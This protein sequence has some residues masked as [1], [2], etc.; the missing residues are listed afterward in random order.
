[1]SENN[2]VPTPAPS[3]VAAFQSSPQDLPIAK[4]FFVFSK[5]FV[6]FF[7]VGVINTFV[8]LAVLNVATTIT[9]IKDGPGF[10]IQKALSF[11]VAVIGSYFLNKRWTFKD[12]SSD[13]AGKKF[14]Q[15][16]AISMGGAVINTTA[17][18]LAVTYLKPE[19]N[20]ALSGTALSPYLTDQI[21]V[22]LAALCGTALGL[23][24]NF[25]GYKFLVFKK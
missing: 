22:N 17:A 23:I 3:P 6:K 10:A 21:W 12:K 15:F 4:S 5:Q 14:S 2:P 18:T 11:F 16:F 9:G 1:M 20:M 7:V 8:D 19:V 25:V 24:W 13:D